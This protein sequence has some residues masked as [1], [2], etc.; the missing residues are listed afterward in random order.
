MAHHNEH[1]APPRAIDSIIAA[2][3][4]TTIALEA[5]PRSLAASKNA[6]TPSLKKMIEIQARENGRLRAELA[7]LEQS[8][9]P[10]ENLRTEVEFALERLQLAITDFENGKNRLKWDKIG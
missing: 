7:N 4:G 1:P 5:T 9:K 10:G 2:A 6:R 3:Q 8:R